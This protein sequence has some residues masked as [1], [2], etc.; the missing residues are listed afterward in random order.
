MKPIQ[1]ACYCLLASAFML[2]GLLVVNIGQD[3]EQEAHA[4]MV[5]A[6]DAFTIA[7]VKTKDNEE[8]LVVLNNQANRL[9]VYTLDVTKGELRLVQGLDLARTFNV[10]ARGGGGGGRVAP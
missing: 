5:L 9:F 4:D 1:V 6:R 8:A 10:R 7:T 3:L 2:G